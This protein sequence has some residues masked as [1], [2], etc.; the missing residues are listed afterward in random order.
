M[1][2]FLLELFV[3]HVVLC[4]IPSHVSCKTNLRCVSNKYIKNES[5]GEAYNKLDAQISAILPKLSSA[6]NRRTGNDERYIQFYGSATMNEKIEQEFNYYKQERYFKML[7]K[8]QTI[9]GIIQEDELLPDVYEFLKDENF[10]EQIR[11]F[12]IMNGGLIDEWEND[13]WE[14]K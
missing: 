13:C 4:N 7:Q 11:S 9:Q 1:L 12:R 3:G 8:L 6:K 2:D 5:V 10:I 14:E